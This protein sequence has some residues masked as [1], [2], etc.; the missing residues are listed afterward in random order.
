MADEYL[1]VAE[2][3]TLLKV[4][5]ESVRNWINRSELRAVRVGRRRVR[6][7]RE[8]PDRFLSEGPEA[9]AKSEVPQEGSIARRA[10]EALSKPL[11]DVRTAL[12]GDDAARLADAVD[13]LA[14]AA[15]A[16]ARAL[17]EPPD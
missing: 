8:D 12:G 6:V 1:T 11:E 13:A 3:A 7:R 4:N 9:R 2:I 16:L 17:R 14:D 5:P 10:S 15:T